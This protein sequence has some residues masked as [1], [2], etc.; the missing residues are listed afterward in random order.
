MYEQNE[1]S[2]ISERGVIISHARLVSDNRDRMMPTSALVPCASEAAAHAMV[3]DPQTLDH[4]DYPRLL[5]QLLDSAEVAASAAASITTVNNASHFQDALAAQVQ[6]IEIRDH[7]DLS[8]LR[9]VPGFN[10]AHR[11][12]AL[13]SI[14]GTRSIRVR[15]SL[16]WPW[17]WP[18][19]PSM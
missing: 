8:G 2:V 18:V 7:L 1:T 10:N 19:V 11:P 13:G 4:H 14:N 9:L 15:F 17:S 12:A 6:D 5:R 3:V 16:G